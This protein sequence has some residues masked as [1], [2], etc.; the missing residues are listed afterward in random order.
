MP[1]IKKPSDHFN[2]VLYTGVNPSAATVTTGFEPGFVWIKSRTQTYNHYLYNSVLGGGRWVYSNSAALEDTAG[3]A[4][5]FSS[6]GFT[7]TASAGATNEAGQGAN[8]LISWSWRTASS[9]TTNTSGTTSSV[10]RAN[11]TAGISV[12][13]YI[14]NNT[15]GS[16]VGHGLGVAPKVIIAKGVDIADNWP[17]GHGA[18][19][20]DRH[21][22]LNVINA[23]SVTSST[24]NN[25]A[26]SSSVFTLGSDPRI[27]SDTKRYVA[28]CF[29][30]VEGFS[31][32]GSYTGNNSLNG[33][34]VYLGFKPA[35][36]MVKRT[37]VSSDWFMLDDLR[38]TFNTI[39][40]GNGGQLAA[41]QNYVESTLSSYAIADFLSN[42][43]KV[44]GDMNYGYWNA[45]GGTYAYMAFAE[46]P[47]KYATAR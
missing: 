13:S 29:A 47:F 11:Q 34:F 35:F 39:G 18:R 41:N 40:A 32:F 30:E 20:W 31:R 27:N 21:M 17:V 16:T 3:D 15:A 1:I 36:F 24:W 28:F 14:G 9:N 25:T 26:P 23:E 42:G 10:V 44:R 5:T 38:P 19:G 37:D 46:S 22:L 6:T 43:V 7:T 4:I 33:P 2:P 45:S 8:N 12:V